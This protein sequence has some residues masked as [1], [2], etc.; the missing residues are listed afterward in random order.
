V[1]VFEKSRLERWLDGAPIPTN[2]AAF[3]THNPLNEFFAEFP[4]RTTEQ[5]LRSMRLMLPLGENYG[6]VEIK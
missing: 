3:E 5:Q 6:E 1:M 2:K 4:P